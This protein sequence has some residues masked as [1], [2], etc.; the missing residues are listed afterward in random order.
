MVKIKI[1]LFLLLPITFKSCRSNSTYK[2]YKTPNL[3]NQL[4]LNGYYYTED[5]DTLETFY[6]VY[7]LYSD[8]II[9]YCGTKKATT[10]QN[11]DNYIIRE[12]IKS[13]P[14]NK[15]KVGWGVF[16]SSNYSI[17]F[18]MWYP[19]I[20]PPIYRSSGIVLNDS[21]FVIKSISKVNGKDVREKNEIYHFHP[22][23]PKPDSTNNFIK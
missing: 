15:S 19:R 13:Q 2:L 17:I 6:S 5:R 7:F 14:V 8:G 10:L 9:K 20:N 4:K 18:D 12:Y 11:V 16:K 23:H 1:L 22:F 3:K 21:T